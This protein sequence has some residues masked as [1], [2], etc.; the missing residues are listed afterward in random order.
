MLLIFAIF[1]SISA[2]S[3]ADNETVSISSDNNLD[4]D[5][6]NDN[7]IDKLTGSSSLNDSASVGNNNVEI[8]S[9]AKNQSNSR[10]LKNTDNNVLSSGE[11]DILSANGEITT[12]T[13]TSYS[14][15][16]VTLNLGG[17]YYTN[18]DTYGV[19]AHATLSCNGYSSTTS[20]SATDAT[21]SDKFMHFSG[22]ATLDGAF[23]GGTKNTVS[24]S[25]LCKWWAWSDSAGGWAWISG[26][27]TKTAS[28]TPS[29]ATASIGSASSSNYNYGSSTS[30]IV[31]FSGQFSG[32]VGSAPFTKSGGA[33]IYRDGSQVATVAVDA[34]GKWSYSISTTSLSVG[35]YTFSV[36]YSGNDYYNSI[37]SGNSKTVVV[38]KNTPTIGSASVTNYNYGD[39][40]TKIVYS[41]QFSGKV[42][43]VSMAATNGAIILRDG[44]QVATVNVDANGKWSYSIST[45][46]LDAGSYVFNQ[47]NFS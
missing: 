12:C 40:S 5:N 32:K 31:V 3:A 14:V 26:T 44:S 15:G 11:D 6:V 45:T 16:K 10:I 43:S 18:I 13:V 36:S 23:Y 38:S 39:T 24:V 2:V 4:I 19:E 22:S 33:V 28:F 17:W 30:S 29:K 21:Q 37:S 1:I 9:L 20:L 42:N 41:G 35:S 8:D 34:D 7:N 25:V 46:S 47:Y 27:V